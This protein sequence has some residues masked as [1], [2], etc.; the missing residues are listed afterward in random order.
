MFFILA[1]SGMYAAPQT[2]ETDKKA[3]REQRRE[4]R[5]QKREERREERQQRKKEQKTP[6]PLVS[7]P[8]TNPA[9]EIIH[10]EIE[11]PR[12]P[13]IIS[14][15]KETKPQPAPIKNQTHS[16][17][18]KIIQSSKQAV[19]PIVPAPE[20]PYPDAKSEKGNPVL[21][22]L[23]IIGLFVFLILRWLFSRRCG[24]CGRFWAMRV[25]DEAYLGRVKT[26]RV[27]N[28]TQSYLVHY[29]RIQVT[30]QC[31]YCGHQDCFNKT[32]KGDA[33]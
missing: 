8:P 27:K 24:N 6:Q 21:C 26:E 10:E 9:P 16:T 31:K 1:A 23:L 11:T 18:P 22:F 19:S 14:K 29:N 5:R 20:A 7:V 3:L 2:Q 28:G 12:E 33:E 13:T 17:S 32:V 25:I 30:R 15:Q 4:E